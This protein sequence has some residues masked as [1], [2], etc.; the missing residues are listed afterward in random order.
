MKKYLSIMEE[1]KNDNG[2][3]AKENMLKK[4]EDVEGLKEIFAFTFNTLIVTGLAKKKIEKNVNALP[5]KNISTIFEA[6]E[7]VKEY[8]TGNDSVIATIK[9]FLYKLETEEEREL[10]KSIL[11]KDLPIGLSRTTLNKVYGSDFI[12]KYTVQLADKYTE[13]TKLNE[14]FALTLKLDGNRATVFTFE[15]GI[16]IFARSGKEIEELIELEKDFQH[17]PKNFVFDGEIIAKNVD[18]LPSKDLFSVTQTLVKRK[19]PKTGLDFVVFDGL[20][21]N[22]FNDGIS[23]LNYKDRMLKLDEIFSEN[24]N[25]SLNIKRVPTFYVGSDKDKIPAV[26]SEVEENGFEGLM[27]NTLSGHYQTKRTKSLLKIKTFHVADL[28]CLGINEEVRGGKCGSIEV[29]YKGFKL[30]VPI[31]KHEDQEKFW[32]NPDL[33]I[34]KI[35]EVKYF[36]ESSNANGGKSLRF[37]T[38]NRIR[39]EKTVDDISFA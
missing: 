34:G 1:I 38:F 23:K 5:I 31:L 16:K 4:Y 15:D 18:N 11:T 32:N 26:L 14:D 13:K 27:L 12:P 10:A 25:D 28:L 6:I 2:R 3:I 35:I 21:I 39:D 30:N 9:N 7:F 33:V 8:N 17:L 22:E 36:E 20:P 24:V 29:D 19:G 37:P